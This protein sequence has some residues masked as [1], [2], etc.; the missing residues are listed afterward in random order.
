MD[1]IGIVH[2]KKRRFVEINVNKKGL[3]M[4][5]KGLPE[6]NTKSFTVLRQ[7]AFLMYIKNKKSIEVVFMF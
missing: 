2:D 5:G 6:E 3:G 4:T 1:R 7:Y